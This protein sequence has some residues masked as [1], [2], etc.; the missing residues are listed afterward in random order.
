MRFRLPQ[1]VTFAGTPGDT[2]TVNGDEV[3]ITVG[4]ITAGSD[5]SVEIPVKVSSEARGLFHL[6]AS[7]A[8]TSATALP[9]KTNDVFT[10]IVR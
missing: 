10:N 4:R 9:V 1:A 7:A 6:F 3:V 8:V 2:I 5:Q